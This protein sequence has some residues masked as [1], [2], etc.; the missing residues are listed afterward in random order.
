M[1]IKVFRIYGKMGYTDETLSNETKHIVA[2][3]GI[4]YIEK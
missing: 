2:E 4:Y 1:F 3:R